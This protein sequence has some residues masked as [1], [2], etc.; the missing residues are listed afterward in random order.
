MSL[1]LPA[2]CSFVAILTLTASAF[3]ADKPN[4][5]DGRK[6]F[7]QCGSCHT[8]KSG[9]HRFGPSLSGFYGRKA[10]TAPDFTYSEGMKAKNAEGLVWGTESLNTFLTSPKAFVRKTKMSFKGLASEKDRRNVIAY[11]KRRS[12]R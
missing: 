3:A 4:W 10:G 6:V 9:E 1:R 5:R 7:K 2:V 8:F 11:I 12:K